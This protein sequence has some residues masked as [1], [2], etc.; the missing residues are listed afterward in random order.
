[1]CI[2]TG[3]G[4]IR[5][6]INYVRWRQCSSRDKRPISGSINLPARCIVTS[7]AG[8]TETDSPIVLA[9]GLFLAFSPILLLL[10]LLFF[11]Q[12]PLLPSI[13]YARVLQISCA[14]FENPCGGLSWMKLNEFQVASCYVFFFFRFP[15]PLPVRTD[16]ETDEPT[17][18]S[19]RWLVRYISGNAYFYS[20]KKE[21]LRTSMVV[22]AF[23]RGFA[24]SAH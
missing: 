22:Q 6:S 20:R 19:S 12:R 24:W 23:Q 5:A 21:V 9:Q 13:V 11:S 2:G 8:R 4:C 17:K 16:S 10:L 15:I 7:R 3:V 14:C 1:M 18:H